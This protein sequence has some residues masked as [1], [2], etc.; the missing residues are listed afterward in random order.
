M[1]HVYKIGTSRCF[2]RQGG[3]RQDVGGE[4]DKKSLGFDGEDDLCN[5]KRPF[6]DLDEWPPFRKVGHR[7]RF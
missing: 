2:L 1:K 4:E 5:G 7:L 6:N 3:F